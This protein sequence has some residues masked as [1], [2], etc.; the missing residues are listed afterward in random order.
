MQKNV[1]F[2][3]R[4]GGRLQSPHFRFLV[5]E[6]GVFQ[7]KSKHITKASKWV[8]LTQG[9]LILDYNCSNIYILYTKKNLQKVQI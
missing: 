4:G 3:I 9:C 6:H 1:D 5:I 2:F 7:M 8:S